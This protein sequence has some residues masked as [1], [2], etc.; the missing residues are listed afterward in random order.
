MNIEALAAV[1]IGGPTRLPDLLQSAALGHFPRADGEVEVLPSPQGPADAVLAFTAHHAVAADVD[2]EW[3]RE[4][5]P[6]DDLGAP[7]KAEFL[8]LLARRLGVEAGMLDVVLAAV[9]G[10][11]QPEIDLLPAEETFAHTRVARALRYRSDVR[12]LRDARGGL[13]TIGNGLA[14]RVEVSI[15]VE[16]AAQG[17]GLGSSLARSALG[18]V[19]PGTAVFAQV[20]PGNV[21]SLRCFLTAGYRPIGAEVLFCR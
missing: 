13:L 21:G 19:R 18:V 3:V 10:P 12:C 2:P 11:G 9:A 20:S 4:T 17:K 16:A 8:T 7:M 14:G 15:E 1:S 6:A 5:L